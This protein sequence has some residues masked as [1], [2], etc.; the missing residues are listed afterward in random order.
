MDNTQLISALRS[1]REGDLDV[2]LSDTAEVAKEFN[3]LAEHLSKV[4]AETRRICREIGI[5]SRLGGQAEVPQARGEWHELVT[6]LNRAARNLTIHIRASSMV[7]AK[8]SEGDFET[9]LTAP[10]TGEMLELFNAINSI[11]PDRQPVGR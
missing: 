4:N 6:E 7:A 1:L 8:R 11:G 2:R 9:I 3:L 5:D 10:A